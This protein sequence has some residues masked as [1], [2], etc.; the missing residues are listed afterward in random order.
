[1]RRF[2]SEPL[3]HFAVLGAALFLLFELVASDEA[4]HDSK[5]IEVNREALLT[6]VQYRTRAFEPRA[7]AARLAS[8]SDEAL[9][10]LID[11]YVREEALHREAKALGVDRNDYVIKRRMIQSLEFITDGFASAAAE[12]TD[13]EVT[14]YY[15]AHRED[16]YVS[17]DA[18]FTH[19]FIG[20]DDRPRAD[21]YARAESM[22]DDLNRKQ[23][24][25]GDA[26]GYGDR[27]PYLVN[28]VSRDPEFVASH[29]GAAM[30]EAVF[31]LEPDDTTWQ[32]PFESE[33][34]LH[35]VMLLR[36]TDGRFPT[37]AEIEDT[38]REDVLREKIARQKEAAIQAIVDTYEV[39]YT[40]EA[41]T[42]GEA[43]K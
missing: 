20:A 38:V 7:A 19:V 32:G 4:V 28:Y 37:L 36:R 34:G 9:E 41:Q 17:P 33:F 16:Y 15:E 35:L 27:F 11:D 2:L 42:V 5:V 23:V 40:K 31:A 13:G 3:V 39:R 25:F 22:L 14:A 18:T 43:R 6:F 30:A 12:V 29:F 10:R 21:T 26:S 8:L 1:M 24:A